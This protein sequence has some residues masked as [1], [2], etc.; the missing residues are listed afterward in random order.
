MIPT[1]HLRWVK[2]THREPLAGTEQEPFLHQVSKEAQREKQDHP[3]SQR[4]V[5]WRCTSVVWARPRCRDRS[6]V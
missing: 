3:P 2:R 4:T 5:R 1:P 6:I